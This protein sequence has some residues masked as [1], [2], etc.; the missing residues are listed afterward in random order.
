[1]HEVEQD[2]R[3]EAAGEPDEEVPV[4]LECGAACF[5]WVA[6]DIWLESLSESVY[7]E[8]G[9]A[10]SVGSDVRRPGQVGFRR[11]ALA[12]YCMSDDDVPF[13]FFA[14]YTVLRLVVFLTT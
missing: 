11:S 10:V 7:D 12:V 2:G 1:M 4:G 14:S 9:E 5:V 8:R 6:V 3:A 13:R